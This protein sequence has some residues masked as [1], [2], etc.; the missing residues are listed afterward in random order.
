MK[1]LRTED[2]FLINLDRVEFFTCGIGYSDGFWKEYNY[3]IKSRSESYTNRVYTICDTIPEVRT[4]EE[5]RKYAADVFE[6]FHKWLNDE[7]CSYDISDFRKSLF[8]ND[9]GNEQYDWFCGQ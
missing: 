1:T 7:N 2:N 8:G 9:D 5:C 6:K 3:V 4:K